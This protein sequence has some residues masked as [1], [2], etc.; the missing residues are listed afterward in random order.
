M[1]KELI[2]VLKKLVSEG[3]KLKQQH[4]NPEWRKALED[5]EEILIKVKMKDHIINKEDAERLFSLEE[6]DLSPNDEPI[7]DEEF[8]HFISIII[9]KTLWEYS[10]WRYPEDPDYQ[11][12][13]AL[14]ILSQE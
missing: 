2:K 11:Y 3:Y 13:E 9:G 8:L 5:A 1:E 7:D 14:R 6:E 10:E 12:L 4:N